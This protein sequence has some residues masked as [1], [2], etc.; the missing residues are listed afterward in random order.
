MPITYPLTLPPQMRFRTISWREIDVTSDIPSPFTGQ[1]TTID[2]GGRWFAATL[3]LIAMSRAD[4]Q[5]CDALITSLIGQTGTFLLGM[6]NRSRPLGSAALAPGT[7]LVNGASQSGRTLAID[8]CPANTAG[9]L[10]AG[11]PIQ[12]GAGASARLY[13]LLQDADTNAS[14]QATLSIWPNLR[15]PPADNATVVVSGAKGVF[16]RSSPA[17][18]WV[19]GTD[20]HTQQRSFDCK[21]YLT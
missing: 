5:V 16:H 8:G 17:T 19:V 7:P 2:W 14:G 21:E 9:Y 10:K 4:A 3:G 12:L 18:E 15:T 6:P 13:K 1:T 11:D 20:G